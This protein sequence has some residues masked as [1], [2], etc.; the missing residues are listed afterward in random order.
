VIKILA[1]PHDALI[2]TA[3]KILTLAKSFDKL[4]PNLDNLKK[5]NGF[6]LDEQQQQNASTTGATTTQQSATTNAQQVVAHVPQ[7]SA[8][9]GKY[10]N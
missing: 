3:A 8:Q 5:F 10:K 6:S 4:Y 7:P 9:D 1:V 2:E